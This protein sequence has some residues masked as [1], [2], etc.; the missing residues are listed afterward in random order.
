MFLIEKLDRK[1]YSSMTDLEGGKYGDM[2]FFL[3]LM[4]RSS[5]GILRL[6]LFLLLFLLLLLILCLY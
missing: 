1:L 5:N 6:F 2:S 4:V 3:L